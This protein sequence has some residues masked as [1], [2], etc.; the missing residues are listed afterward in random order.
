MGSHQFLAEGCRT[1]PPLMQPHDRL[2]TK[3]GILHRSMYIPFSALARH[4]TVSA[5]MAISKC[6]GGLKLSFTDAITRFLRKNENSVAC[7]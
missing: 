1:F 7:C 6:K 3:K 2:K 5:G 4:T